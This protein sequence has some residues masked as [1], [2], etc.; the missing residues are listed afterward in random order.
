MTPAESPREDLVILPEADEAFTITPGVLS[1]SLSPEIIEVD[2]EGLP[3]SSPPPALSDEDAE[4]GDEELNDEHLDNEDLYGDLA[5]TVH[6]SGKFDSR[7]Y[8]LNSHSRATAQRENQDDRARALAF[9]W[10]WPPAFS[11]RVATRPGHLD[12]EGV[13]YEDAEDANRDEDDDED[14]FGALPLGT[15][16]LDVPE[17]WAAGADGG[18]NDDEKLGK[19]HEGLDEVHEEQDEVR[20]VEPPMIVLSSDEDEKEDDRIPEMHSMPGG[21]DSRHVTHHVPSDSGFDPL[22]SGDFGVGA[23]LLSYQF[24]PSLKPHIVDTKI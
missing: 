24:F 22:T 13:Q 8:S 14:S 17:K 15:S 16:D 4:N 21:E 3:K 1:R 11:G 6:G 19:V 2:T 18:Q 7:S 9:D 10:N 20:G 5:D 23:F 12:S